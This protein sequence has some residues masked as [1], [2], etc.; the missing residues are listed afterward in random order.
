MRVLVPLILG[1]AAGLVAGW[2]LF[3]RAG[4]ARRTDRR[5]TPPVAETPERPRPPDPLPGAPG[6]GRVRNEPPRTEEAEV[7]RLLIETYE[8]SN[9]DGTPPEPDI[10]DAAVQE[11]LRRTQDYRENHLP[12]LA[13]QLRYR[14]ERRA[15]LGEI[16]RSPIL[17]QA[18]SARSA[19]ASLL[20]RP[21]AAGVLAITGPPADGDEATFA[22]TGVV[23]PGRVFVIE[24]V[25][26]RA[27][28]SRGSVEVR[29]PGT[30]ELEWR[31]VPEL[32]MELRGRALLRHGAEGRVRLAARRAA[33]QVE[34]HGRLVAAA[35]AER[36][37]TA[38]LVMANAH[39][40]PGWLTG[41]PVV[42]QVL[43]D[44]GGGNPRT[45]RLDGSIYRIDS[46][47]PES[48]WTEQ[49]QLRDRKDSYAHYRGAGR[50]PEGKVFRI[51]QIT[52]RAILDPKRSSHSDL[53]LKIGD[54]KVEVAASELPG[55][56]NRV[57]GAWRGEVLIRRGDER[58]VSLT[59][60]YFGLAEATIFG[61]LVDDPK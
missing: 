3:G 13:G 32:E 51:T 5:A 15:E 53:V 11:L 47:Q 18:R 21:T 49:P 60:S 50:V 9:E 46:L 16:E 56:T 23:P 17:L 8:K 10:F 58:K 25:S 24:R 20:R 14:A 1:L 39:G 44:H 29:L 37:E 22:T 27:F 54:E 38:P 40:I 48:I 33:A 45:V 36:L 2:A 19:Q 28:L 55:E 30:N 31:K 12:Y 41:E 7:R 34:L 61:D 42:L 59:C 6:P 35:A 4:D 43:A 26:V 57:E 52:Y